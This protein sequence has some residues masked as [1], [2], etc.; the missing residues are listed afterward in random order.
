LLVLPATKSGSALSLT[1][2]FGH[3]QKHNCVDRVENHVPAVA[4]HTDCA[5]KLTEYIRDH[6]RK[7]ENVGWKII[8]PA[9]VN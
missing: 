2:G 1:K 3:D 7:I 5:T 4:L 8:K 9:S 6:P